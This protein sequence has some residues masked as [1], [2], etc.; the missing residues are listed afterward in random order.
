MPEAR[1]DGMSHSYIILHEV[2]MKN[3]GSVRRISAALVISALL[4]LL[5]SI[6]ARA[7]RF[8]E[9]FGG[10]CMERGSGGIRVS[11]GGYLSVGEY[12]S[13]GANCATN[14]PDIYVVKLNNNG[15]L[16][17]SKSYDIGNNYDWGFDVVECSNGDFAITGTTDA[18]PTCTTGSRQ[19]FIL[20]I[21]S[22]GTVI[23]SNTYGTSSGCEW[24]YRIIE[25]ANGNFPA[26]PGD[27]VVAGSAIGST[28]DA[29]LFRVN[30]TT[31]GVVW[32]KTFASGS[33]NEE[34][35]ALT[36]SKTG[37]GVGDIIAAGYSD[38]WNSSSILE[39]LVVRVNG[40]TGT[41]GLAP[42][43]VATYGNGMGNVA[44][45][46]VGELALGT[47]V[48]DLVYTGW[49][50]GAGTTSDIYVLESSANPCTSVMDAIYG[51]NGGASLDLGT[52]IREVNVG[53]GL[54]NGNLIVTGLSNLRGSWGRSDAFLMELLPGT[55]TLVT[56]SSLPPGVGLKLYGSGAL[57]ESRA[58]VPVGASAG[59]RTA[60]FYMT[61]VAVYMAGASSNIVPA[62][63]QGEMYVIKTN[64]LG[65]SNC[66]DTSYTPQTMTPLLSPNCRAI[67]PVNYGSATSAT[68]AVTNVSRI[69]T[70]CNDS[71][72]PPPPPSNLTHRG[73]DGDGGSEAVSAVDPTTGENGAGA[74]RFYPNPIKR[75]EPI[76]IDFGARRESPAEIMVTDLT[77]K[78]I[79]QQRREANGG[80]FSI[81]TDGWSAGTYL[82]TVTI[83]GASETHR[84]V[85]LGP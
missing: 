64:N 84:V 3:H 10:S 40:N 35:Y 60:G 39:G 38:G 11:A 79:A 70:L 22:T 14:H 25:A 77:G 78:T 19:A 8:Q 61:G 53:S 74:L 12:Y 76:S 55:L 21:S 75:G 50:N 34:F 2:A 16:A 17:W 63:D 81:A 28:V 65:A 5:G 80:V 15:S 72:P 46:S 82:V 49:Y 13:T 52:M 47:H 59:N 57:E 36:E 31:G 9:L 1:R 45:E 85:L 68:V 23:W 37:T 20:R 58:V 26:A 66:H 73:N 27:L 41:I 62:T 51:D 83:G 33:G 29:Y 44:F 30:G 54:N 6:S 69:D 7:Q 48:S 71:L 4:L 67:T 24:G 32:S 43:G 18:N 42:Q 56:P